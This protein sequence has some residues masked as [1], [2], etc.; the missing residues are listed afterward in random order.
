MQQAKE[1][2]SQQAEHGLA[3]STVDPKIKALQEEIQ[4]SRV[5]QAR[6]MDPADKFLEGARL[7]DYAAAITRDGI[8]AQNPD[9]TDEQVHA[10][11][12][13]RLDLVRERDERDI[14][15]VFNDG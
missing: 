15:T 3:M 6:A 5:Q 8:R 7:F 4:S 13:R 9:F 14:Y 10:E 11:F 2:A 12:L 1:E